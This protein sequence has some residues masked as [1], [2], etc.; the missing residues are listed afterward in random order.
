MAIEIEK[1]ILQARESVTELPE[2]VTLSR[3]SLYA[4]IPQAILVWQERTNENP[5]KR[6]NFIRESGE[7]SITDGTADIESEVNEKGFRLEYIKA[8]DIEIATGQNPRFQVKFVNSLDR[9]RMAG[10]QDRF[11]ILAYLSG[12]KITFKDAGE[13]P[14]TMNGAFTL[15]SVVLPTD[16]TDMNE[17][18]LPELALVLGE[19]AKNQ[20]AQQNRGLDREVK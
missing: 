3:E 17:S 16:L 20:L 1:L 14:G 9:L 18:V 8:S 2:S 4:L 10:I 7:I 19:L 11:F 15:R 12:Y 13:E 5:Q 6:Q